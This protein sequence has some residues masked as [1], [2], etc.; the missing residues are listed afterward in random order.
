MARSLSE[1][2]GPLLAEDSNL[3]SFVLILLFRFPLEQPNLKY[4]S[5]GAGIV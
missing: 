2:K 1:Y 3:Y 4:F 5:C